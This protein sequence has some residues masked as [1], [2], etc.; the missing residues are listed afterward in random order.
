MWIHHSTVSWISHAIRILIRYARA[1]ESSMWAKPEHFS[2]CMQI[3]GYSHPGPADRSTAQLDM[4]R[5]CIWVGLLFTLLY[6]KWERLTIHR[7][8]KIMWSFYTFIHCLCWFVVLVIANEC[9]KLDHLKKRRLM[10][11]L[12]FN[13]ISPWSYIYIY[14][15]ERALTEDHTA[16][17]MRYHFACCFSFQLA[18]KI[19]VWIK[20]YWIQVTS[21]IQAFWCHI[22]AEFK[23]LTKYLMVHL[24]RHRR[25]LGLVR[26]CFSISIF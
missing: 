22:H 5:N 1:G 26:Y 24:L 10:F 3:D 8:T 21:S 14:I 13:Q 19:W 2:K 17:S 4:I 6:G 23:C 11:H 9:E 15:C 7:P 12:P 16:F 25:I 20:F 18:P